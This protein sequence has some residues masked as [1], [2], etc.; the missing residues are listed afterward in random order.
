MN[1]QT[2]TQKA[3]RI[4]QGD[5]QQRICYK[6]TMNE[7]TNPTGKP[8]YTQQQWNGTKWICLSEKHKGI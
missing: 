4:R 5:I 8:V 2:T 6:E 1:T 7:L 3:K